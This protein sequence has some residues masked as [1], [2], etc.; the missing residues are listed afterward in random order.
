[1]VVIVSVS[2]SANTISLRN[3]IRLDPT[4][5]CIG[6]NLIYIHRYIH[7]HKYIH[8]YIFIHTQLTHNLHTYI[9]T[10]VEN[11]TL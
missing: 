3:V 5:S 6:T 8:T 9:H 10:F 7:T 4:T 2:G 1:M 11:C